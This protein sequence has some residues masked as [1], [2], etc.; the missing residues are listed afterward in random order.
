MGQLCQG[1][2]SRLQACTGRGSSWPRLAPLSIPLVSW[3]PPLI[4]L[5]LTLSIPVGP[6]VPNLV[7]SGP[8]LLCLCSKCPVPK[9][10]C[11]LHPVLR[12]LG[13]C[14]PSFPRSHFG[15]GWIQPRLFP[16]WNP[17]PLGLPLCQRLYLVCLLRGKPG[18]SWRANI[19]GR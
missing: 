16:H 2:H 7:A 19:C 14:H 18:G 10:G 1:S 3:S 11:H 6:I 17:G 13:A 12:A 5:S 8:Q 9:A 4:L 15:C